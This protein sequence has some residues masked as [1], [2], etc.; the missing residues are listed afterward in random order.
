[1]TMRNRLA[2]QEYAQTVGA[3]GVVTTEWTTRHI[4]RAE[5]IYLRGNETV[6]AA[7]LEGRA[8][9]K[10]KVRNCPEVQ[11]ITT[12]WRALDAQRGTTYDIKEADAI[13]DPAFAFFV[14]EGDA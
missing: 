8:I 13:T 2:F 14:I 3:G 4:A 12:G 11:A 10:A 5:L 6:E 9:F 7:R 1:M